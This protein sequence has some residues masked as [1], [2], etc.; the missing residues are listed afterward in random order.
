MHRY[1]GL[2]E[3]EG[4]LVALG[5]GVV[6]DICSI[7]DMVSDACCALEILLLIIAPS[8]STRIICVSARSRD[9][10]EAFQR[11]SIDNM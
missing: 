6:F 4:V 9:V 7:L 2:L 11:L 10:L 1:F 8:S 5:D 3:S